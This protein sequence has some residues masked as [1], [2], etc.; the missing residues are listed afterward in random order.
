MLEFGH[1][2]Y[3]LTAAENGSFR[4]AAALLQVQQSTISRAVQHVEDELG[5]SL[6]E[7]RRNGIYPTDAG[8]Q[9]CRDARVILEQ[10]ELTKRTASAA[11]RAEVGVVRIGI[12]TSLAGGFL[13]ELLRAYSLQHPG[14]ELDI[15]DGHR[16]QHVAAIRN[17]KLDIALVTGDCRIAGCETATL[18]DERV[19][20]ALPKNHRLAGNTQINWSDLRDEHFIVSRFAPGLQVYEY[21]RNRAAVSYI[22][23]DI[24]CK[25][26]A[27]ETLM[28]LV[29][30]GYGITMI[31]APWAAMKLPDLLLR[32]LASPA[33]IVSFS[34]VWAPQN[35]N[36]AL[37]RFISVAHMLAGCI[38]RGASDWAFGTNEFTPHER[39]PSASGQIPD[40]SP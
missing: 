10:L 23:I 30:M 29:A 15:R 7:R 37:R 34:A 6:F 20:V 19:L 21:I 31:A 9:F 12:L 27:Q 13:R 8:R 5:V 3:I 40:R 25:S 38:R 28:N 35:D 24:T 14:I 33:D 1:L 16:D 2:R 18:W 36:P 17:R 26:V 11:G 32:P 4:R 22:H 39:S